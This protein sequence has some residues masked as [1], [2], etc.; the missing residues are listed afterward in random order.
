MENIIYKLTKEILDVCEKE[1]NARL[2][3]LDRLLTISGVLFGV[4]VSLY[5][6]QPQS[7]ECRLFFFLGVSL[8]V[9][10]ILLTSIG[11]YRAVYQWQT[12]RR[13]L[14]DETISVWNEYR[15]PKSVFSKSGIFFSFC[16]KLGYVFLIF[17]LF[18]L[19][20]YLFFALFPDSLSKC[21]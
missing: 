17:S 20:G 4:L 9:V 16:E 13:R 8:L 21:F 15:L 2:S 6:K 10:G 3:F 1:A 19:L 12:L 14:R 18:F 5:P 7:F 11:R